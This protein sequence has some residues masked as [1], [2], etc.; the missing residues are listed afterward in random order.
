MRTS[1]ALAGALVLVTGLAG[2]T[3]VG[4]GSSDAQPSGGASTSRTTLRLGE[5]SPVQESVA[6]ASKGARYTVAVTQVQTG[7]EADMDNSGLEQDATDQPTIPVYVRATLSHKGGKAMRIGD[8]TTDLMIN[9]TRALIV[10]MGRATWPDCPLFDTEKKLSAGQSEK[11]CQVFL[12][13]AGEK[14]AAVELWQGYYNDPL[15]WLV[16]S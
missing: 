12:I 2:C 6:S 15:R 8:M 13:P 1:Y 5:A 9:R 10:I 16:T 14:P 3:G 11:V 7:T 4:S